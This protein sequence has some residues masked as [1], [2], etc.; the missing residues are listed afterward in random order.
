MNNRVDQFGENMIVLVNQYHATQRRNNNPEIPYIEHLFG[1]ASILKTIA[2]CSKEVSSDILELMT[3]AALGH[4]LLEDTVVS[5][6]TIDEATESVVLEWIRE[7][8]NPNDDAHT[9]EYM[10]G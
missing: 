4:D 10:E 6:E 3:Q 2:E 8:T 1:V 7:L 9:D 5:E